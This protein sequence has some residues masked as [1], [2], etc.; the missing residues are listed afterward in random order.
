MTNK[1]NELKNKV[2]Y[3]IF[4]RNYS[5]SGTFNDVYCDLERI[6]KLGVDIIWFMPFYPIGKK[7]RKGN[8]GSPYSISKYDEISYEYGGIDQF[9]KI[10]KKS[11]ELGM[12]V[13]IDIVFNHT[14]NDSYISKN[15]KD[16]FI[17]N[18]DGD[19]FRK[20]PDWF[21]IADLNFKNSELWD[22]L[23]N[24]LKF[25]KD[26][27]VEG[28]RCDVASLIPLNFW[29]KA[30]SQV[31][32][33]KKLIWL[34]ESMEPEYLRALRK[35]GYDVVSDTELY[36]VFDYTYDYDGYEK[37]HKYFKG[38]IELS[39]I[40]EYIKTQQ[41]IYP[42]E[43][44]KMRFLE[45]HDKPRIASLIS[46]KQRLKNWT[47]FYMTLP[48]SS[49]IYAGQEIKDDKYPDL[50]EKTSINWDDGDYEFLNFIKKI[51]VISK[52]I[53]AE[54]KYFEINEVKKGIV[55]IKWTGEKYDYLIILNL[56]EKYGDIFL[57]SFYEGYDM[58]GKE[59]VQLNKKYKLKKEPLIIKAIK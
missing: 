47:T 56:E 36:R 38:E 9:K 23:I 33:E 45:N 12:Q 5:K 1:F 26:I 24:I 16:W 4:L 35:E 39:G 10:I 37:I 25:W 14:S 7:N 29:E 54:S 21:D 46:S 58:I 31:D 28:F 34:A 55:E 42:R 52:E 30:R 41:T 57:N 15:H 18:D 32:P 27:G 51:I 3:E 53:K 49:L 19:F 6:K 59:K 8:Y 43:S 11:K 48:G 13:M 44:L 22:Y 50:F 40:V 2:I 17:L 20:E